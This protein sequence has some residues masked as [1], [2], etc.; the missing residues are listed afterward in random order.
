MSTLESVLCRSSTVSA[1]AN[2]R[3]KELKEYD[4]RKEQPDLCKRF[5]REALLSEHHKARHDRDDVRREPRADDI[6]KEHSSGSS[7]SA[8]RHH[9]DKEPLKNEQ[10]KRSTSLR[11]P[12]RHEHRHQGSFLSFDSSSIFFVILK[13]KY[14]VS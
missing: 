2:E 14:E 1:F 10:Q 9:G 6:R 13:H 11:S 5:E 12:A 7:G 4:P 8:N 3:E